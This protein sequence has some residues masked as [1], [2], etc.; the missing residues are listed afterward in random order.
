MFV[1]ITQH[2]IKSEK[3]TY[4]NF[5]REYFPF[6]KMDKSEEIE[7]EDDVKPP[8]PLGFE[9]A[10]DILSTWI[11]KKFKKQLRDTPIPQWQLHKFL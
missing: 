6:V 7:F 10:V 8:L 11:H 5:P 3:Q 4:D 2:Y 9:K 1:N